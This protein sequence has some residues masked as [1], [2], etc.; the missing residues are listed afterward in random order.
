MLVGQPFPEPLNVVKDLETARWY[1]LGDNCL[2]ELLKR[3][4]VSRR[5]DRGSGEEAYKQEMRLRSRELVQV[6]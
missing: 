5:F 2:K 6:G 1:F 4:A 3:G